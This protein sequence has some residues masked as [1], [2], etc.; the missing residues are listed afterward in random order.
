[1]A[2]DAK[3]KVKKVKKVVKP[4]QPKTTRGSYTK[5]GK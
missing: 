4:A 2:N 3:K 5:R 1:M